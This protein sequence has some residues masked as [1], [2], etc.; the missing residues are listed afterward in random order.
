MEKERYSIVFVDDEQRIIRGIRRMLF[1]VADRWDLYFKNSGEEVL[2]LLEEKPI[3]VVVSDMRM[4]GMD[5]GELLTRIMDRHP[6][7]IRIILSGYSEQEMIMRT[8]RAA[9]QFIAKPTDSVTLTNTIERALRLRAV[10]SN[11][12]VRELVSGFRD[13]PAMSGNCSELMEELKNPDCSIKKI[14]NIISK[15]VVIT[16]H[17]LKLLNSAFF[18]LP[19][20]VKSVEQAVS[21]LGI[22]I[23]KSLLLYA[24][25]FKGV[26][27]KKSKGFSMDTFNHHSFAVGKI[28]RSIALDM[29]SDRM[30]ADD[31]FMSGILHD[32]GKLVFL[33][34][35]GSSEMHCDVEDK[36]RSVWGTT[37]AEVG[38]YLL[39]LWGFQDSLVEAVMYHHKP[40]DSPGGNEA[41][42]SAVHSAEAIVNKQEAGVNS[43]DLI[44]LSEN[45]LLSRIPEWT[46]RFYSEGGENE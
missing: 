35:K 46:E 31:A 42:L 27:G 4:P 29:N 23:I 38:A 24:N 11:Q 26:D 21:F 43:M 39:G 5:G 25:L 2:Q 15:D 17:I 18:G 6:E 3:D 13:I 20:K 22:N 19:R 16:A 41:L 33:N 32:I 8:V 1:D 45:D 30:Q 40:S 28:A 9:H 37:H 36:E 7:V 34:E 14:G 12:R 44:Y 10:L